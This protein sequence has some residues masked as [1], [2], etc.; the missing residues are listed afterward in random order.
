[1]SDAI[2][3]AIISAV[4]TLAGTVITIVITSKEQMA[5]V[6]K[7]IAIV[8]T[9]MEAMSKRIEEHNGYAKLFS[10]NIPAL[11]QHLKDIDRRLDSAERRS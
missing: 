4:V 9:K 5:E 11:K 10:E 1:M 7:K 6:D 8:D 2:I 3:C